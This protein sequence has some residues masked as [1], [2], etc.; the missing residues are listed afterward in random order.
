YARARQMGLNTGAHAGE[1]AGADSVRETLDVLKVDRIGH[2]VRAIEDLALMDRLAEA[3]VPL[4]VCPLSNV[5]TSVVADIAL[6]PVRKLWDHGVC[7]T[8]NT[9][10]PGMF[11]NS[12]ADEFAVLHEVFGFSAHEIRQLILNAIDASWQSEA[13]KDEL[14]AVCRGDPA[15]LAEP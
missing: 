15:W 6:H 3:R 11:H 14:L 13:C 4:E 5:A 2:G 8:I 9:D 1:A 10:D 12:L 7:V